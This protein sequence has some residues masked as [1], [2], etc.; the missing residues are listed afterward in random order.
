MSAGLK[1]NVAVL[2]CGMMGQEHISYME[3][4]KQINVKFLCDPN[5]D[6]LSK[7]A[8]L[9]SKDKED[10]QPALFNFE[11]QLLEQVGNIDLLVIATPNYLHTPQLLRWATNDICILVE[12]PIAISE[13]QVRALRAA[14]PTFKAQIWTAMEYRFIPAVNKLIQLL[15]TIGPIKNVTIREN[16]FPFLSKVC[17]AMLG[18]VYELLLVI[19]I[20]G[21]G[22]LN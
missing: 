5:N 2:G 13:K 17:H 3:K 10:E 8:S 16:R 18:V 6:M 15:P 11:S 19:N 9:I 12:K 14:S 1:I 21:T 7:A 22:S 20:I 4:Y